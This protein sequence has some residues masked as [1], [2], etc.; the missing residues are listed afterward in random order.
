MRAAG[1]RW[2]L[3]PAGALLITFALFVLMTRM[4]SGVGGGRPQLAHYDVVDFV[5]L[6]KDER[7]TEAK[8][9]KLPKH[10]PPPKPPR[11]PK[12]S[13]RQL[14]APPA[15]DMPVPDI[16]TDP[17]LAGGPVIGRLA[18]AATPPANDNEVIP[19][20]RIPPVYPA[21]AARLHLGGTVIVEFTINDA[22]RVQDPVVVKS[23]PP[24]IFD[25]A[26]IR[27]ILRWKFKPKLEDGKAVSRRARQRF[28]FTPPSQ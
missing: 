8:H 13:V 12:M 19:L 11:P 26:A 22:G 18:P 27:A 10:K 15:P 28:D 9:E 7:P 16:S 20:V 23:S 4:I 2:A 14:K 25:Q 17:R 3:A 5:R 6:A 21:R 24:R 1:I